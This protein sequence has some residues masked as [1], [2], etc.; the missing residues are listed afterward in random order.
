MPVHRNLVRIEE[1]QD[2]LRRLRDSFHAWLEQRA[3]ADTR[4]QYATQLC[5]LRR[6]LTPLLE[7]VA[8]DIDAAGAERTA[9]AAYA[10]C[11]ENERRIA[12][13]ERYWSYFGTK[14][15]QRDGPGKDTL[16]AADEVVWSCF[17]GAFKAVGA[18]PVAAP[19][20]YLEPFFTPRAITRSDPPPD[21]RANDRL[22][23]DALRALPLP[24]VGLPVACADRPWWLVFIAHE[25]GHHV[26]HDLAG[27]ALPNAFAGLVADAA[28]AAG[29]SGPAWQA[30][31]EELFA[32]CFSV[33]L[34]G[35]AAA[36]AM[37]E[38]I[39]TTP[40]RMLASDDP[41]YPPPVVR[42]GVM[43]AVLAAAG[44]APAA[45][46]P[47]FEAPSPA[48]IGEQGDDE[49]ARAHAAAQLAAAAP[50]AKALVAT[51]LAGGR[52]L[53]GVC[54]F[55]AARFGA[56]GD[57]EWWRTAWLA[58]AES[59]APAQPDLSTARLAVAGAV[60]AW[61]K[62]AD[63]PEPDVRAERVARLA[64]RVR[65]VLPQCRPE[66]RRAA[67]EEAA[68]DVGPARDALAGAIFGEALAQEA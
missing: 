64:E 40:A 26:E 59:M 66:G 13:L 2:Q 25:A 58:K 17:A 29:G 62:V 67:R 21:L 68:P 27:A 23:R 41:R 34:A 47:P 8:G 51:P 24:V 35:T 39:E 56:G 18:E 61:R 65:A 44:L 28:A 49:P 22:L 4:R 20:P 45:G 10:R 42:A 11:R 54:K 38:L 36:W 9:G 1:T 15:D 48:D 37:A 52:T 55:D 30:W 3:K 33:L 53:P 14:W 32:D 19:L 31:H 60:A 7:Q 43:A 6:T 57:V 50:V 5:T 16:L 12:F 63:E 46:E